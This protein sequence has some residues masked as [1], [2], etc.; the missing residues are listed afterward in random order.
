[1][2]GNPAE[3]RREAVSWGR[4]TYRMSA[5]ERVVV[6]WPEVPGG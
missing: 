4:D 3:I 5:A 1:V 2:A 6:G